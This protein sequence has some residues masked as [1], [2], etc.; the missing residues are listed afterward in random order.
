MSHSEFPESPITLEAE[1]SAVTDSMEARQQ[2]S[3]PKEEQVSVPKRKRR[4]PMILGI[5]LVMTGLGFGWRWWQ[6]SLVSN[7]RPSAG[8]MAGKPMGVPVKLATVETTTVQETSEFIGLL[9]APRSVVLKPEI[10]GRVRQIVVK[11]GDRVQ[12]GQ[13]IISL[14]SDDAQAQLSQTKAALETTRAKL[15]ELKA[16][17]RT[18]EIAQ[19][20]AKLAQ[21]QARLTNAQTGASPEEIAQAQSQIEVAKSELELAKS[22]EMRYEKLRKEGAVS[23][24]QLEGYTK[25]Q[26]NA[27]AKLQEAQGRLVH[28]GRNKQAMKYWSFGSSTQPLRGCGA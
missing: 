12:E 17:T 21:A 13:V 27:E 15:A 4:W 18:E 9:E 7:G 23:Q 14:E 26:R 25:E 3:P 28:F 6:T 24:D 22:R 19:A 11:E 2:E 16:G 10:A 5:I 1:H 8:A 20:R